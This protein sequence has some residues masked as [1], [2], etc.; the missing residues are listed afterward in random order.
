M[1]S[2]L[3]LLAPFL[4]PPSGVLPAGK[5]PAPVPGP[6]AP[7]APAPHGSPTPSAAPP[8]SGTAPAALTPSTS[9]TPTEKW[10]DGKIAFARGQYRKA[11]E[12]LRALLRPEVLLESENDLVQAHRM[13]G[14]A[15][16]FEN[17]PN[18]AREEFRQLLELR[19]ESRFDPLLDP[20]FIVDFFNGVLK[21]QQA[22]IRRLELL[23]ERSGKG[24]SAG[25][26]SRPV[27][28]VRNPYAICFV[29][30]GA[31]QFQNGDRRKGWAFLGG[32][33]LFASV[34][35]AAFIS[36]FALYGIHP[37]RDC[38][39]PTT[40][41]DAPPGGCPPDRI[42]H[43]DEEISRTL[44]KVQVGSGILFFATAVWGMVDAVRGYRPYSLEPVDAAE[45]TPRGEGAFFPP[46]S[47]RV[48]LSGSGLSLRF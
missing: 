15:F 2:P 44:T 22:E 9:A 10:S 36:N 14:V 7:S 27:L 6:V 25:A 1:L 18:A 42:D 31:G 41:P 23:R 32:E 43:H 3:V 13:L 48:S 5:P 30:F 21:E 35:V 33:T 34:S 16:L 4:F 17:Q 47:S 26:P 20:P 39:A 12:L 8:P 24:G 37:R 38:L 40:G 45:G 28:A 46:S 11:I 29:P 19:P